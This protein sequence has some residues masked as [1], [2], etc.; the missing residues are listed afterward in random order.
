MDGWMVEIHDM[1][2]N[3]G[4]KMVCVWKWDGWRIFI[5]RIREIVGLEFSQISF[6]QFISPSI[7]NFDKFHIPLHKLSI[8]LSIKKIDTH[9]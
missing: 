2:W 8:S 9:S 7:M 1:W 3:R 6:H 4:Y 5:R